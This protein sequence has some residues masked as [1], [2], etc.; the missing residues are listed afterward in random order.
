MYSQKKC[1]IFAFHS[2]AGHMC[3]GVST[4]FLNFLNCKPKLMLCSWVG[5]ISVGYRWI[6][7]MGICSI[8]AISETVVV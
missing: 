8:P 3:V 2:Y 5:L 7:R 6:V 1:L 4:V